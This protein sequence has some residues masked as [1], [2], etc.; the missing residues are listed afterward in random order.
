[1]SIFDPS[2]SWNAVFLCSIFVILQNK[3]QSGADFTP[4]VNLTHTQS[5]KSNRPIETLFHRQHERWSRKVSCWI[6]RFLLDASPDH[7]TQRFS[8]PQTPCQPPTCSEFMLGNVNTSSMAFPWQKRVFTRVRHK[9][10]SVQIGLE[11]R[12]TNQ[13]EIVLCRSRR[14]LSVRLP[15]HSQTN[16]R[17]PK[18][19]P[20]TLHLLA[21]PGAPDSL[22]PIS[23]NSS[24]SAFYSQRSNVCLGMLSCANRFR[25]FQP[26]TSSEMSC[27]SGEFE[28]RVFTDWKESAC[29]KSFVCGVGERNEKHLMFNA[30]RCFT[31]WVWLQC[32]HVVVVCRAKA[33]VCVLNLWFFSSE[34]YDLDSIYT[35]WY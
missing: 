34:Q 15:Q 6:K 22:S 32:F 2:T 27:V 19:R 17:N 35:L 11:K 21:V 7:H 24:G 16:T 5:P 29:Q 30:A 14:A 12:T 20:A 31:L 25:P 4:I 18:R 3:L 1:M 13:W 10:N 33:G 26:N 8:P 23:N 9:C 28:R